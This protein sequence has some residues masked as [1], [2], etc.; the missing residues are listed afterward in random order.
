MSVRSLAEPLLGHLGV[1]LDDVQWGGGRLRV[2]V[3][4]SGGIDS[5]TLVLVSRTI[6]AELDAADPIPSRY[7]LEVTSPGIERPLRHPEHYRRAVGSRVAVKRH[8]GVEGER[9]LEGRL[10]AADD[11]WV[12]LESDAG[13]R[14]EIRLD[15]VERARTVF[16]W[17]RSETR[18]NGGRPAGKV[19]PEGGSV[20]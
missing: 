7:T 4:A 3:E 15:T 12:T 6:S 17:G 19:P 2:V 13:E 9:R 14:E 11:E 16:D 18:R 1:E 20:E 5:E 10:V 8:P